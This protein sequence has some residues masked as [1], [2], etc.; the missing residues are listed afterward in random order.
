[1]HPSHPIP[2]VA[3]LYALRGIEYDPIIIILFEA[4]RYELISILQI[5][6]CYSYKLVQ[7]TRRTETIE[8]QTIQGCTEI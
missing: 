8:H 7:L 1:M 2:N 4:S 5:H 6:I 3:P